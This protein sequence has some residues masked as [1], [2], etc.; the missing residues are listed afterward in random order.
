MP[1]AVQECRDRA[2][3]DQSQFIG[4]EGVEHEEGFE[5]HVLDDDQ[6]EEEHVRL[7]N[8]RL[9][10]SLWRTC[11]CFQCE[12]KGCCIGEDEIAS[13]EVRTPQEQEKG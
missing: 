10:T 1:T 9:G 13:N 5:V 2:L 11:L 7:A 4:L 12:R 6:E 8:P 3:P